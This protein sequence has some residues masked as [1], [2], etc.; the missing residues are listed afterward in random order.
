MPYD[1]GDERIVYISRNTLLS[2]LGEDGAAAV[3]KRYGG[4]RVRVP[5]E[6]TPQFDVMV[7]AIGGGSTRALA[8]GHAGTRIVFARPPPTR[9]RIAALA[10]QGLTRTA[11]AQSSD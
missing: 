5:V 6:G 11:I 9:A 7:E 3:I 1:S 2:L 4:T 8:S 10:A